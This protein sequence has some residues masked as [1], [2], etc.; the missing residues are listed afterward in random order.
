MKKTYRYIMGKNCIHEV[1]KISPERIVEVFTTHRDFDDSLSQLILKHKIPLK[2]SSKKELFK[3]VE[4]ESHQSFV[5]AVKEK[6]APTVKGF[7]KN[8]RKLDTSLVLILDSLSDPQNLG[9]ILRASECFGV[10]LVIFSKNRGVDLTPVV[11]KTSVGATEL[12]PICKVSNLAETIKAFQKEDYWAV[13]CEAKEGSSSL[14]NFDFPKK[15]LLILGSEGKGI[16]PLLSKY[17]DFHIQIP[18]LGQIDSL[19]VSQAT[20]LFLFKFVSQYP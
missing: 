17:S 19:N 9:T 14:Y 5:A 2:N 3:L 18:M 16:Q 8:A 4:S 7:L 6:E 11:S 13:A 15:T 20:A 12:V 1:L 10:D